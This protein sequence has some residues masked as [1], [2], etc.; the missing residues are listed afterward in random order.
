MPI[1]RSDVNMA[2]WE[3]GEQIEV[4]FNRVDD[5]NGTVNWNLPSKLNV[6]DGI[7][8]LLHTQEI[9]PSNF[10]VDGTRYASSADYQAPADMIDGA[11]V[12]G[13]FY[14][15]KITNS[16]NVTGLVADEVYFISAHAVDN[17]RRYFTDGKFSYNQ[18]PTSDPFS[19]RIPRFDAPPANPVE[20]SVYYNNVVSTTFM[21]DGTDW[22]PCTRGA[23]VLP[24][25]STSQGGT[26]TTSSF[27]S[28][29]NDE[30]RVTFLTA[31]DFPQDTSATPPGQFLYHTAT[32]KLFVWTGAKWVQANT[33]YEGVPGYLTP[34]IGTDGTSDEYAA[35]INNIKRQLGW[36][37]VCVELKEETFNMAVDSALAMFR[38]RADNAY[39]QK[40]IMVQL[41]KG[42]QTYYLND[43]ANGTDK[44]VDVIKIG[45]ASAMGGGLFQQFG[46]Y[47]Q[48]FMQQFIAGG[49]VDLTSIHALTEYGEL[50]ERM[51][52]ADMMF[53]WDE[54]Q[55]QL[56]I[57]QSIH[58][59]EVIILDVSAEKSDQELLRDRWASDWIEDWAKAECMQTLGW[60][61]TK[62]ASLPG[63][64]GGTQL[65]G[66]ELLAASDT[67]FEELKRQINDLEVGNGATFGNSSFVI[68]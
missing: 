45:R 64:G 24:E 17:T 67:L 41:H 19:G 68:G 9:E 23:G 36:P 44:I 21:F 59:D 3:V 53:V 30:F 22:V 39:R 42:Q 60:I 49:T 43:P 5:L 34:G 47:A 27:A 33:D 48:T 1:G 6:Y 25:G 63:A 56:Q 8:I 54:P 10:P 57:L 38:R 31:R 66:Q 40:F 65:N 32:E 50:F 37:T 18:I 62:Y 61:R 2:L 15:D 20:G 4:S 55:R 35:I 16:L 28:R 26:T 12:V 13:A 52:A 29:V 58:Y 11:M 7:L 46:I 51:F 14:G